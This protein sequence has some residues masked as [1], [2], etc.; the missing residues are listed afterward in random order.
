[1]PE[2]DWLYIYGSM[3]AKMS[4]ILAK[5]MAYLRGDVTVPQK[6]EL[7]KKHVTLAK[8]CIDGL[9]LNENQLMQPTWSFSLS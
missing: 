4:L 1:M 6:I 3:L 7:R 9:G 2:I 5:L 8:I